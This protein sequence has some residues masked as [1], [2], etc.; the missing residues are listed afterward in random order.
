MGIRQ[1]P[2]PVKLIIGILAASPQALAEVRG[3]LIALW[4]TIDGESPAIPFSFTGYYENEMGSGLLRQ[5]VSF[6][7]LI[8]QDELSAIKVTTNALEDERALSGKRTV[9]L[10]PGYLTLS[11]LVLA[12]TKDFSHRIYLA[13]G[14]YGEVT[15]IYKAGRFEALPWTYPDY[16]SAAALTFL[17]SVR[18]T[19]HMQFKQLPQRAELR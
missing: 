9:N 6:D 11:R 7:R 10:D 14:V 13:R 18:S 16:L 4:G 19:Y 12:S 1:A 15:L 3:R 2:D 17:M 8:E 5:W